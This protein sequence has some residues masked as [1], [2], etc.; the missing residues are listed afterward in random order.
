MFLLVKEL[1]HASLECMKLVHCRSKHLILQYIF[2]ITAVDFSGFKITYF[3][4]FW[5]DL[6]WKYGFMLILYVSI[7]ISLADWM[8]CDTS[9]ILFHLSVLKV[10]V[11]LIVF[12]CENILL[13]WLSVLL[14]LPFPSYSAADAVLFLPPCILSQTSIPVSKLVRSF[15]FL[16]LHALCL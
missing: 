15:F 10:C 13:T 3:F 1:I 11:Y 7:P 5:N 16:V 14:L 12:N 8:A 9:V 2:S 4:K 6:R